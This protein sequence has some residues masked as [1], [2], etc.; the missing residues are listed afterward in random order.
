MGPSELWVQGIAGV[1]EGHQGPDGSHWKAL[2]SVR[3]VDAAI[4]VIIKS[5]DRC[6]VSGTDSKFY[7]Q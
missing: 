6:P 2:P 3:V 7:K 1:Q 4:V 5:Q